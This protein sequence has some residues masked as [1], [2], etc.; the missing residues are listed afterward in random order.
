MVIGLLQTFL[1]NTKDM[2]FTFLAQLEAAGQVGLSQEGSQIKGKLS[3]LQE[4]RDN[5][6]ELS[7]LLEASKARQ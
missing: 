2:H 7:L 3:L 1:L 6:L 5:A 4:V